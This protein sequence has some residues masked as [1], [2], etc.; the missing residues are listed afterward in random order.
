M[1]ADKGKEGCANTERV[2]KDNHGNDGERAR[3]FQI[4]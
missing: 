3:R 4:K 2:L 1:D